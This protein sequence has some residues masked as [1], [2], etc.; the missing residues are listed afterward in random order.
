M[1]GKDD[2]ARVMLVE[3]DPDLCRAM[4]RIL[5]E[6]G[7]E[8]S[9]V[10]DGKSC[11]NEALRFR[12][13][14][15]LMDVVLPD[16]DGA[17]ICLTLKG[18]PE[19]AGVHVL[20]ISGVRI[21][22]HERA[23]AMQ[24]GADGYLVKPVDAEEL[25]ARV[26]VALRRKRSEDMLRAQRDLLQKI[27]DAIPSPVF[28]KDR[29]GSYTHCNRAFEEYLGLDRDRIVGHTVFDVAPP[30][31]AQVYFQADRKLFENPGIQE[32]ES[33]VRYADGSEHDVIFYKSTFED[34]SGELSGIVGVILDITERKRAER[35]LVLQRDRLEN[36]LRVA[37]VAVVA[38]DEEGRVTLVNPR[39]CQVLGLPEERILGRDWF[40]DFLPR[41]V[42]EEVRGIFRRLMRGGEAEYAEGPVLTASGEERIISWH[43]AV[44]RDEQGRITGTL[45]SGEDI[46]EM[47]RYRRE[48]E[49]LNRDLRAFASTLSHDLKSPLS[50]AYGWLATLRRLQGDELEGTA[51]EALEAAESSLRSMDRLIEGM[52]SYVR[53]GR[54]AR[55]ITR[56]DLA[57]LLKDLVE[58]MRGA[59][60]L[61]GAEV[62]FT[63]GAGEVECDPLRLRQALRNLLSNA[64]KFRHEGRPC[65]VEIGMEDTGQGR[66]LFVRDNGTGIPAE[67]LERL[68]QPLERGRDA[69]DIPGHGLGLAIVHQIVESHQGDITVESG[70]GEGT[71]FRI[72]LPIER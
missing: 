59:G 31:L 9:E 24:G 64:S 67:E 50:N 4:A 69:R 36:Y 68:F 2:P 19:L 8:V 54:E 6:Q 70:E 12:P 22:A 18:I 30:E 58:E 11:L 27:I 40:E 47:V 20:L 55:D 34:L 10:R 39:G 32:Y 16:G 33:R 23:E 1:K 48:L 66:A 42:R 61:E 60:E 3:D 57:E 53:V 5:R 71:T 21:S 35:E 26:E 72:T 17:D 44:I 46:T 15:V 25:A 37:G 7:H 63:D 62:R 41:R 38:L 51:R 65:V 43:N 14:L 52:L 28:V 29:K 45:S 13:D 56:V 49:E